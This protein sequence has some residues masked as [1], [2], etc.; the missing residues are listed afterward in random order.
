MG[1][2][3][4]APPAEILVSGCGE[5][6]ACDGT[7]QNSDGKDFGCKTC[8]G[9]GRTES[10]HGLYELQGG[11]KEKRPWY[12]KDD[13]KFI[14]W[15]T[16]TWILA[17]PDKTTGI[18]YHCYYSQ[19]TV[20][21]TMYSKPG[22]MFGDVPSNNDTW[23]VNRCKAGNRKIITVKLIFTHNPCAVCQPPQP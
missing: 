10:V 5:C 3:A 19:Y 13:G 9:S 14:C 11:Q 6:P 2:Y 4:A 22:Q 12:A 1:A 16:L 17:T 8:E 18:L 15:R 23:V 21:T 20:R 7:G